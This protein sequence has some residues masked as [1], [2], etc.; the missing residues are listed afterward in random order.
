MRSLRMTM[1]APQAEFFQ[2][3]A[4]YALFCGGYGTGKTETMI[5]CAIRDALEAPDCLIALYEPTY[6]LIDLALAPRLQEKL[7]QMGFKYKYNGQR[8]Y[9]KVKGR[10]ADF[11]LR[12]LD[13]PARIVAYQSY[14]A[15][16]DEID[17]LR[18][19]Q[20]T[21]AWRKILARNR[22]KP[23]GKPKAVNKVSAYTTPEG[24]KFAYDTWVR[25]KKPGDGFEMVR[26]ATYT[27]LFMEG[28]DEYVAG[29]R[30]NYP[31]QLV[32]AYIEG[33]F[34]NMTSGS[35][36]PD[37]DRKLNHAPTVMRPPMNAQAGEPLHVGMDFNVLHMAAII[38]VIRDDQPHAVA[39]ITD[40]RDT[41]TMARLI[42]ERYQDQGHHV[43]IY[44][45]CA[46]KGTSSKD[47]AVSDLTILQ[48]AGFTIRALNDHS[49]VKD[50]VNSVNALILNAKGDRRLRVNTDLCPRLTECLEQQ[51]YDK[52]GEP[53][54]SPGL[55]LDHANDA[56]GYFL[57]QRWPVVKPIATHGAYIPHIG[58]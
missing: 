42:K 18:Q 41:P 16:I 22:Q 9:F 38:F 51:P 40:G 13:N 14:R 10:C 7:T 50:R 27:N 53:D 56:A 54:K 33:Q 25:K 5:N 46:A 11:V 21:V 31:P 19:D 45:D 15:H 12:T 47:A 52:H 4:Q 28:V 17:T 8:R 58:R 20:A 23:K 57:E 39:E 44:P 55:G 30:A 36:Y 48:R 2:L 1:T 49:P 43:T 35:V 6:D 24:Y 3:D 29:L 37:F 34:V 32:K 26:A